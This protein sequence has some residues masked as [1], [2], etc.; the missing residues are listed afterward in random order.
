MTQ[1]SANYTKNHKGIQ[2]FTPKSFEG[3]EMETKMEDLRQSIQDRLRKEGI[4]ELF[5]VQR[6]TYKVFLEGLEIIVK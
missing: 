4:K 1:D 2:I 3:T 6:F 5:N